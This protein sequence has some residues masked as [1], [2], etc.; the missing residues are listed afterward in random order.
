[1]HQTLVTSFILVTSGS[2]N[3]IFLSFYFDRYLT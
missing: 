3:I 1:M 2:S